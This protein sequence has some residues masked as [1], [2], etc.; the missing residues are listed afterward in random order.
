VQLVPERHSNN[1]SLGSG[2]DEFSRHYQALL[3]TA[4][5]VA[6]ARSMRGLFAELLK[7]FEH[8]IQFDHLDFSLHDPARNVLVTHPL[9]QKGAFDLPGEL[10]VEGSLEMVLQQHHII[11]VDD[12]ETYQGFADLRTMVQKGGL[13]SFRIMPL[14]TERRT[15]GTLGVGRVDAGNFSDE[16]IRFVQHVAELV[17]LVL[18]NALLAEVLS[19]ERSRLETL[20]NVS[21]ALVSSLNVHKLFQEVPASIRRLVRQGFAH[22]ALYD[23]GGNVM[24]KYVLDVTDNSDFVPPNTPVPVSECQDY[25]AVPISRP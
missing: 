6:T 8:N 22:L 1:N 19:K 17:A 9:L 20:L 11:E 15:L 13:R 21:T 23:E 5:P 16:D 4:D 18:E 2:S 12:V 3:Q 24:R 7:Q 25:S 14:T 10:P